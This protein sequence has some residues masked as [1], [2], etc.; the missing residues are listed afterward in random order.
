MKKFLGVAIISLLIISNIF[1]LI[2]NQSLEKEIAVLNQ[3]IEKLE[4]QE[5]KPAVEKIPEGWEEYVDEEYGFKIWY[6]EKFTYAGKTDQTKIQK[7]KDEE[8][9]RV[10]FYVNVLPDAPLRLLYVYVYNSN[11]STK[12]Y[13]ACDAKK[14]INYFPHLPDKNPK[15][16][17]TMMKLGK[18][19]LYKLKMPTEFFTKYYLKRNSMIFVL[20]PE[21]E[22]FP[23]L[24][25]T[26]EQMVHSF[27]FID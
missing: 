2:Q 9:N 17:I 3:K 25:P 13:V 18:L 8:E 5:E 23:E 6:P 19:D 22:N 21:N 10:D 7:F 12:E 26:F 11:L 27:Q 4:K 16:Y 15:H 20:M 1:F 24:E 14:I